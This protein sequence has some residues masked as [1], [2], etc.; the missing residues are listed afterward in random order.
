VK[1]RDTINLEKGN[2]DSKRKCDGLVTGEVSQ[3][4][5]KTFWC[6]MTK[7]NIF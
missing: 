1:G 6:I 2:Y 5:P 4:S 3:T 7:W